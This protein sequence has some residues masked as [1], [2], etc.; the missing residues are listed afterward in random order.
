M[1][2]YRVIVLQADRLS[3]WGFPLFSKNC[4]IPISRSSYV[5]WDVSKGYDESCDVYCSLF[6]GVYLFL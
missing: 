3:V 5:V 4:M 1:K 2:G 6:V